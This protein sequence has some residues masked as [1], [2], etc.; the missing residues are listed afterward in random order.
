MPFGDRG[1]TTGLGMGLARLQS[2]DQNV[3]VHQHGQ[4][5]PARGDQ[6]CETIAGH[7]RLGTRLLFAV[8][9]R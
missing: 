5:G 1:R 7:R 6:G 9:E 4:P 3:G 2:E 8:Q